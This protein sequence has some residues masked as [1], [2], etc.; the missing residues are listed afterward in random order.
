MARKR[1]RRRK[2]MKITQWFKKLST[3]QKV[4]LISGIALLLLMLAGVIYV[5]SIFNKLNTEELKEDEIFINEDLPDS[6]G[7]GYTNFVLFGG[8]SRSGEVNKNLNTDTIIIVSL[9]NETKEVKMVSVYRDT[10]LDLTNGKIKKCNSAYNIGGAK[11][12]I[13]MLNMNLDLDIKK[14]VTV[15]FSAVVDLVDMVG[16]IEVEVTKAEMKEMNKFIGETASV[17]GKK[18]NYIKSP[19]L[20]KLDGVQATTYS[21]IRKNVGNDFA[22]TERQRIVIQKV[23]EKAMKSNWSTIK[24]IIDELFPRISTNFTM[25]EILSYAKDF[26]KYK[27]GETSGF[28]FKKGS[29]TIPGR[30]SSVFP[31]TLKSNVS[32]LHA[33][34]FGTEDYQPSSKVVEISGE[35]AYIVGNRKPDKDTSNTGN[36]NNGNTGTNDEPDVENPGEGTGNEGTGNEG[37][38]N[39]GTG[40]E[41]TGNEGTGNE[42]T[43]NEGTGNEG[44]GNEG[45]GNEGTGNEGTGNEGTGNEGTG[46][47]GTQPTTPPTTPSNPS[48]GDEGNTNDGGTPTP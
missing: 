3:K 36:G 27:F 9:N 7:V 34:L 38:G 29:G 23:V 2:Q 21:R 1:R 14:Y 13:N 12:A 11:Q 5:A 33:F 25:T 26:T 24:K 43:G 32:E 47:E 35:I 15:D 10:L 37:T 17:S 16:G 22:R 45:T 28:P 48:E 6:I 19:G 31:I 30:G 42:G 46:N 8:D 41:G 40:N 18:A 20:Q 4:L 44:T 39:E